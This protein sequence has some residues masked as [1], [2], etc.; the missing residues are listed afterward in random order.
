M[1]SPKRIS[2]AGIRLIEAGPRGQAGMPVLADGNFI[3][4]MQFVSSIIR[5]VV[6]SF[7]VYLFVWFFARNLVDGQGRL[8]EIGGHVAVILFSLTVG[9]FSFLGSLAR[10]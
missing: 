2:L 5:G 4:H 6:L 3:D 9:L 7:V 8:I 10:R 1:A